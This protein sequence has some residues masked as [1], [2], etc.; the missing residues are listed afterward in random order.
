MTNTTK[1]RIQ[2]PICQRILAVSY[3]SQRTCLS[4]PCRREYRLNHWRKYGRRKG[5]VEGGRCPN[6]NGIIDLTFRKPK[7]K[8]KLL[9]CSS[10]MDQQERCQGRQ[11]TRDRERQTGSEPLCLVAFWSHADNKGNEREHFCPLCR[12][13]NEELVT[14]HKTRADGRTPM[15]KDG[16]SVG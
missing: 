4:P 13:R 14:T 8:V 9:S 6:C 1:P 12:Q 2:C 5:I 10:C 3:H 16:A 11:V 15:R 7:E